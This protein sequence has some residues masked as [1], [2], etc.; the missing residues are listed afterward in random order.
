M[1]NKLRVRAGAA[2]AVAGLIGGAGV[3]TA[4]GAESAGDQT[5]ICRIKGADG[6]VLASFKAIRYDGA[7][8]DK[9]VMKPIYYKSSN[10]YYKPAY[11]VLQKNWAWGTEWTPVTFMQNP[12]STKTIYTTYNWNARSAQIRLELHHK[13]AYAVAVKYCQVYF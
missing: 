5:K 9:V 4:Q 11:S 13:R 12:W 10:Y 1:K 6:T 8:R 3:V 2:L 7:V